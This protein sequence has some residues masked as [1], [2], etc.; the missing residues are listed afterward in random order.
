VGLLE[1]N[2]PRRSCSE[3][4]QAKKYIETAEDKLREVDLLENEYGSLQRNPQ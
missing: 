1:V 2:K 4:Q 3:I